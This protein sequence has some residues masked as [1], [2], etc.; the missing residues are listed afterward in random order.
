MTNKEI[1]AFVGVIAVF[2]VSSYFSFR[3]AEELKGLVQLRGI[4]GMAAYV[5]LE[6]SSI[7]IM[8]ITTLPLLPVAV[9]LWGSFLAG[10]LSIIGWMIGG[11]IAFKLARKYGKQFVLRFVKIQEIERIEKSIP[12]GKVFWAIVILRMSLPVD[13]LSYALGL[14]TNISLKSYMIATFIGIAPFAFIFS[15][16]AALPV[17]YQTAVIGISLGVVYWGYRRIRPKNS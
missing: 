5:A 13:L 11:F 9:V 1:G 17:W 2:A 6:V 8:P 12:P 16:S 14:F 10:V 4:F 3:Y 7:V 15:Y